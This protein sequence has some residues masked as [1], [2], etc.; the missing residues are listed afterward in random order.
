MFKM[1][2]SLC[3]IHSLLIVA[4][5]DNSFNKYKLSQKKL[6]STQA[7]YLIDTRSLQF[8]HFLGCQSEEDQDQESIQS[9]TTTD[10]RHHMGK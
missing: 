3:S 1:A 5:A 2:L 7:M 8:A 9:S 6:A 4:C 10:P